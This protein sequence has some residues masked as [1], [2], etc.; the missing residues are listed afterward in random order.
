MAVINMPCIANLLCDIGLSTVWV[1]PQSL[2]QLGLPAIAVTVGGSIP[3]FG[4]GERGR[5]LC[6]F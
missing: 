3:F 2:I 4:W 1:V 6:L 5:K